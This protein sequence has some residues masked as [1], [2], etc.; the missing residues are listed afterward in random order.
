MLSFVLCATSRDYV[1]CFASA[2]VRVAFLLLLLLLRTSPPP[3]C[4]TP[5]WSRLQP[6]ISGSSRGALERVDF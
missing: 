3:T 4:L 2:L 6:G 5:L 1:L